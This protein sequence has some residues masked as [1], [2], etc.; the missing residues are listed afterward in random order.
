MDFEGIEKS[1]DGKKERNCILPILI[2]PVNAGQSENRNSMFRRLYPKGMDFSKLN[3]K[4]FIE[5]Q[6]WMNNYLRKLL[7]GS[8]P[9]T[10]L[11]KCIGK[12]FTIPI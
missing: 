10:E 5:V 7:K 11:Q 2:A 1:S 9:E 4:L 8:T 3:P 6:T 12:E